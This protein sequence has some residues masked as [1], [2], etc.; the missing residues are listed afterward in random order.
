MLL[1]LILLRA[2]MS[3]DGR[4]ETGSVV[5]FFTDGSV[6]PLGRTYESMLNF[7]LDRM[8]EC[9]DYVQFMWPLHEPSAF[10]SVFPVLTREQAAAI[11]AS[12]AAR[13]RMLAGLAKFRVFYGVPEGVVI[14]VRRKAHAN[15]PDGG[16]AA[17]VG[18]DEVADV[19]AIGDVPR[20]SP[21]LN[22]SAHASAG[23]T[24]EGLAAASHGDGGAAASEP[25]T[26]APTPDIS[27]VRLWAHN[28]DHNLLRITRIIRSLRLIGLDDAAAA[29][30]RDFQIVGEWAKLSAATIGFWRRAAL[31]PDVWNTMRGPHRF[32]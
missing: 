11:S 21:R 5:P 28:G 3:G 13:A 23:P 26:A 6:D 24:S 10:A 1:L 14:P 17:V 16:P 12:P 31:D 27:R 15:A 32:G 25:A 9:H 29:F 19:T 18:P 2:T 20:R 8:E 4:D 7:S 30:W 22:A